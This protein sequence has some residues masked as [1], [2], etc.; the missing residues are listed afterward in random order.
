[1][2]KTFWCIFSL[3]SVDRTRRRAV[4]AYASAF[5]TIFGLTSYM[6]KIAEPPT[7]IQFNSIQ[8]VII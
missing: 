7:N 1:M 3:H 2:T 5:L 4:D 8:T 6:P